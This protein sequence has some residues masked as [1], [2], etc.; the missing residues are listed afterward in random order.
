MCVIP[1]SPDLAVEVGPVEVVG[2]GK[3]IPQPCTGCIMHLRQ[4]WI[5]GP[6][7]R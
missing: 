2:G 3:L 5:C 1:S 7:E 6:A 4:M